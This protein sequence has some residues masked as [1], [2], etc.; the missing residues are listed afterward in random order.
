MAY[1]ASGSAD[2]ETENARLGKL[3]ECDSGNRRTRKWKNARA[4][5]QVT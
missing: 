3:D 2:S 4:P 5:M 1:F